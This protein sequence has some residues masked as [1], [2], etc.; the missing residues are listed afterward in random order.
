MRHLRFELIKLIQ[1]TTSLCCYSLFEFLPSVSVGVKHFQCIFIIKESTTACQGESNLK[2]PN[3]ERKA[4]FKPDAETHR[5]HSTLKAFH[6][7][8]DSKCALESHFLTRMLCLSSRPCVHST[9]SLNL[10]APLGCRDLTVQNPRMMR[11]RVCTTNIKSMCAYCIVHVCACSFSV[12]GCVCACA[13][14]L[15]LVPHLISHTTGP[16]S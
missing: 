3:K 5:C 9:V 7:S 15:E 4:F 2:S 16:I 6:D 12:C 13:T 1:T 10:P 11:E 8:R 14:D